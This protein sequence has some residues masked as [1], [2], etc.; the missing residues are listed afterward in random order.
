M[1][2]CVQFGLIACLPYL[3]QGAPQRVSVLLVDPIALQTGEHLQLLVGPQRQQVDDAI[4]KGT[5]EY[6]VVG[7]ALA[8][9]V[10][11]VDRCGALAL[12]DHLWSRQRRL[13]DLDLLS[14]T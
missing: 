13:T 10:G 1:A 14:F 12:R 5:L 11:W 4:P 2:S 3:L 6:G 8:N 7:K 9:S